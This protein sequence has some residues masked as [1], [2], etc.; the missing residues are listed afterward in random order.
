MAKYS[1]TDFMKM[2]I[3]EHLKCSEFPRVGAAIV[4]DGNL[5]STRYRGEIKGIH[6]ERVAIE[7]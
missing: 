3:E 5:L 4:K 6:A 1:H 2:A 7:N